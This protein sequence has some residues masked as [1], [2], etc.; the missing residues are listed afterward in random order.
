MNCENDHVS[1]SQS[2]LNLASG[3]FVQLVDFSNGVSQEKV[4]NN[5][6]NGQWPRSGLHIHSNNFLL[7]FWTED[8][9]KEGYD[10][11]KIGLECPSGVDNTEESSADGSGGQP[12][13]NDQS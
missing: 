4:F 2:H 3:D 12:S 10:G 11:F 6:A 7:V 13:G 8:G 1:I 9:S 5:T